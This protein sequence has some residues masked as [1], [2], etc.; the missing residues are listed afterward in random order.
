ML[1]SQIVL[2]LVMTTRLCIKPA[3]IL[4]LILFLCIN[5]GKKDNATKLYIA[6]ILIFVF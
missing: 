1:L 4:I 3:K 5:M 2:K 6:F